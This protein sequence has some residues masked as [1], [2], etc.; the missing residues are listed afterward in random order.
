MIRALES[1][2]M[3][4]ESNGHGVGVTVTV[5]ESNDHGVGK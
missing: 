3:V 4:L 2:T 1:E 5:L